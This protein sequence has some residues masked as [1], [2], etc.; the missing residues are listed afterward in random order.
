[1]FGVGDFRSIA[2][3]LAACRCGRRCAS[4]VR[5]DVA[6]EVWLG[7]QGRLSATENAR[8]A[9]GN[10]RCAGGSLRARTLA[11]AVLMR[12]SARADPER[13]VP[14]A[15]FGAHLYTDE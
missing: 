10:P 3:A 2:V 8:D 7:A 9:S 15:T 12:S 6:L 14:F 13:L 5:L 11:G 1:M 4:D